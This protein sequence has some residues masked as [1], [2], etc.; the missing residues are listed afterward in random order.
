MFYSPRPQSY[1]SPSFP[2]SDLESSLGLHE[3]SPSSADYYRQ[4]AEEHQ[5]RAQLALARARE[6][7][8]RAA[9]IERRHVAA[10]LREEREREL[11]QHLPP[12][13][14]EHRFDSH[15]FGPSSPYPSRFSR[16]YG[17]PLG[18]D[19]HHLIDEEEELVRYFQARR[20]QEELARREEQARRE[21]A[22][23][24]ERQEKEARE[25]ALLQLLQSFGLVPQPQP[26]E[27]SAPESSKAQC[28]C[29]HHRTSEQPTQQSAPA[30]SQR[31]TSPRANE[32]SRQSSSSEDFVS[33]IWNA[34]SSGRSDNEKVAI[35]ESL[36]FPVPRN[37]SQNEEV[38]R[39]GCR[40]VGRSPDVLSSQSSTSTSNAPR[41]TA[42]PKAANA[43]SQERPSQSTPIFVR[44]SSPK[45][46]E[47]KAKPN[48]SSSKPAPQAA[49]PE[50]TPQHRRTTSMDSISGIQAKFDSLKALYQPPAQLEFSSEAS[51]PVLLY[52][53]NN[54]PF[55]K[56]ENDLT[57]L[58]TKLDEVESHGDAEVREK[59][60]SLVKLIE[61]ELEE[62][63]NKKV[64]EWKKSR[65]APAPVAA[66]SEE[67]SVEAPKAEIPKFVREHEVTEHEEQEI[68]KPEEQEIVQSDH[69]DCAVA[70][71]DD[72]MEETDLK[73]PEPAA[74][75]QV[76][77]PVPTP[78][79]E[80]EGS[81]A[82]PT[83]DAVTE[84]LT[85]PQPS[86]SED[87]VISS[88]SS[89]SETPTPIEETLKEEK[90][91][92]ESVSHSDE[93]ALGDDRSD[94]FS[95]SEIKSILSA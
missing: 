20:E 88:E 4:L 32:Q 50:P 71:T 34:L 47:P 81:P 39:S 68:V 61:A 44:I 95:D 12:R 79:V 63:D 42:P 93:V 28:A 78:T 26:K 46:E 38:C 24:R 11:L 45:P 49:S 9:E 30:V 91:I 67:E 75:Q 82:A 59:R 89:Q 22:A 53:S 52:N 92:P 87:V 31:T 86:T 76:A 54:A 33:N 51:G 10:L 2:Y 36:G 90:P 18:Y 66:P 15:L 56:Y 73:K 70:D 74:L 6:E 64:E 25:R 41:S 17:N 14:S 21:A 48:T 55:N 37:V 8:E 62:L 29:G 77:A 23:A 43:P 85:T 7:Q 69:G 13:Y 16:G 35:L 57:K 80:S 60:K 5:H 27:E 65:P 84:S 83:I 3:Q 58:L 40:S 72:E 19:R 1:Y 94:A